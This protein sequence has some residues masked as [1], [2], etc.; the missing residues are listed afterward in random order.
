MLQQSN[1]QKSSFNVQSEKINIK[2]INKKIYLQKYI[3]KETTTK[4]KQNSFFFYNLEKKK[5]KTKI[6]QAKRGT[7]VT[8]KKRNKQQQKKRLPYF[9][10][11]TSLKG[12]KRK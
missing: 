12:K 2:Y 4:K 7:L 8:P 10:P 6:T 9:Q 1:C 5:T 3:N 11:L